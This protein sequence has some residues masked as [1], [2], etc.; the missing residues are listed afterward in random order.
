MLVPMETLLSNETSYPFTHRELARLVVYRAAVRAGF[1][2]ESTLD[3]APNS[4]ATL[5]PHRRQPT[6]GTR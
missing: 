5:L 2:N 1:Y 4:A 6:I 3:D